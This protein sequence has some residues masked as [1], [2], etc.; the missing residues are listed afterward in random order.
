MGRAERPAAVSRSTAARGGRALGDCGRHVGAARLQYPVRG[1]V[2]ASRAL[3]AALFSRKIRRNGKGWLS[4][5]QLWA[6]WDAAAALEIERT[7]LLCVPA[8]GS[9]RKRIA[10]PA[11][12]VGSG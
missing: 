9:G 3:C 6:Q 8:S 5:G 1:I 4:R 12:L 11:V 2:C 10:E 7:R